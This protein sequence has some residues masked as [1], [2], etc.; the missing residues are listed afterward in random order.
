VPQFELS[1]GQGEASRH[2]FQLLETAPYGGYS[3]VAVAL[4]IKEA[5]IA[6]TMRTACPIVGGCSGGGLFVDQAES[7]LHSFLSKKT[8]QGASGVSLGAFRNAGKAYRILPRHT[9]HGGLWA[10]AMTVTA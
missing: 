6:A 5:P 9:F 4:A 7:T 1:F 8:S 3:G 2:G 10:L